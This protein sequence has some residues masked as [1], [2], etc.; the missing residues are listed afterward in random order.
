MKLFCYAN[1]FK[2]VDSDWPPADLIVKIAFQVFLTMVELN[3][4]NQTFYWC[5]GSWPSKSVEIATYSILMTF[6]LLGNG[7]LVAVFYRNKTL[8]TAVHYFIVN[9]AISDLIVPV[10]DL[11]SSISETY[12]DG[13]W[14]VDGVLGTVLC[15]L[16]RITWPVSTCVS[17]FSMIAIAVDR[18]RAVLFPMKSAL[19]SRNKRRLIIAAT[20]IASV[21]LRAH[22]LY[23]I[24]V[25][26][27]DTGLY[28]DL[29]WETASQARIV[30]LIDWVLMFSL[31]SVSAI[32][33]T[34]LYS[35]IIISLHRG[36]INLHMAN[37]IVRKRESR[38]RKIAYMLVTIVVVFYVVWIPLYVVGICLY[39][40]PH[41]K[42]PCIYLWL[43]G[44]LPLLYPVINPVVYYIF[45]EQYHQ[46]FR[47]LLCCPW[48]C[49]N[50][51]KKCFQPSVSP[52][53]E[54]NA[55]NAE[56]V[57]NDME[58]IELEEQW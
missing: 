23:A 46:G 32:V 22:Y 28:C 6:S 47:E 27:H 49:I 42:L 26:P 48:S 57:N 20:W 17:I 36:T 41:I 8:R 53:G 38:N 15:K 37:E 11:P 10:L 43:T 3:L 40:K 16:L 14:L 51:C 44:K 19:L 12:H 31:I 58:N 21:A 34:I 54:N 30:L 13:L 56:Q 29:Q 7:L 52:Q 24:K 55:H 1:S 33:L 35:S 9:M 45:N 18:F 4:T 2:S 25:V 39:L 5:S 50:K